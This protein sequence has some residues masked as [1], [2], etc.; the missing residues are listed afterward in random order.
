[1]HA[2]TDSTM[3][4]HVPARVPSEL[5]PAG[6]EL[7]AA[8]G[9]VVAVPAPAAR[10][11]AGQV[12]NFPN[13]FNASTSISVTLPEAGE[14]DIEVY[15]ILGQAVRRLFRGYRP[16]GVYQLAWDG[17]DDDGRAAASGVYLV[18]AQRGGV[19]YLARMTLLR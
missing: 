15:N 17:R 16:A 19:R 18:S 12:F 8:A 1:M 13:P 9:L 14:V 5:P 10:P 6:L 4:V 11:M 3:A 7:A 2:L